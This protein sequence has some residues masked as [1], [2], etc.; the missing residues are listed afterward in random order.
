MKIVQVLEDLVLLSLA[1]LRVSSLN[2]N[3]KHALDAVC[4]VLVSGGIDS[5]TALYL[6]QRKYT[7]VY[8]LEFDFK[9]RPSIE[10]E[11]VDK[12]CSQAGV[13]KIRVEYP[14]AEFSNKSTAYL[15]ESNAIYYVIASNLAKQISC[16]HGHKEVVIW[17]GQIRT[18]WLTVP[19]SYTAEAA[20][21]HYRKLNNLIK[22][23]LGTNKI[24]IHTP[25]IFFG[26]NRVVK[27][28]LELGV[29][30]MQTWSCPNSNDAPCGECAQC[31]E[32]DEAFELYNVSSLA[33]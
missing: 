30:L 11:R 6:A 32:R 25:F 18:D 1:S 26:K 19:L 14:L 9:G 22:T 20:P 29:P 16:K 31:K 10:Q 4:L 33:K 15:S 24:R 2:I 27:I 21:A 12:I 7:E 23:D 17:A 3:S 5:T 8:A 13:D 28:A